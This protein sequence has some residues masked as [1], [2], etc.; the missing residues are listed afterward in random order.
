MLSNHTVLVVEDEY[1][2]ADDLASAL[3]AAGAAVMGPAQ[4]LCAAFQLIEKSGLPDAAVLDINLRGEVVYP[5]SQRLS[6]A[7]VPILFVTGYDSI[8]IPPPFDSFPRLEKS[9]G[10]SM[11]VTRVE[12]L[13]SARLAVGA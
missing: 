11:L 1:F 4:S 3:R 7:G 9:F 5:L 10:A 6:E 12:S 8:A 2:I 13:L